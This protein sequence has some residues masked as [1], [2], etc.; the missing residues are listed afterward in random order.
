VAAN[1]GADNTAAAKTL[2]A[3]MDFFNKVIVLLKL[4]RAYSSILQRQVTQE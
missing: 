3:Q 4:E 1:A 2:A